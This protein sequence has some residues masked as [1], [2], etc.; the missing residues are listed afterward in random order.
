MKQKKKNRINNKI[1]LMKN[2]N[3]FML[4]MFLGLFFLLLTNCRKPDIREVKE[5]PVKWFMFDLPGISPVFST[6]TFFTFPY[7]NNIPLYCDIDNPNENN[8]NPDLP[9]YFPEGTIKAIHFFSDS[10]YDANHPAYTYWDDIMTIEH[11]S[12]INYYFNTTFDNYPIRLDSFN[13]LQLHCETS[14][15]LKLISPPTVECKHH[16]TVTMDLTNGEHY[17]AKTNRLYGL[18]FTND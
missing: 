2:K 15:R 3:I 7:Q 17:E 5:L 18:Q 1:T 13:L 8:N 14:W 6:D 16:I 9:L 4:F 12:G 10:A 11:T